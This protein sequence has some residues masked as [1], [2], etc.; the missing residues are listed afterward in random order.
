MSKLIC[1]RRAESA[2]GKATR[3]SAD[4]R[5]QDCGTQLR[6]PDFGWME[7]E[8]WER[9]LRDVPYVRKTTPDLFDILVTRKEP[10]RS[11]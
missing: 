2:H 4:G 5:C 6:R 8:A 10:S 3:A 7:R 9:S 11:C 1:P